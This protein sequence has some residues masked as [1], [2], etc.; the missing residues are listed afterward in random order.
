MPDRSSIPGF[1]IVAKWSKRPCPQ[2]N[3]HQLGLLTNANRFNSQQETELLNFVRDMPH[4]HG[5]MMCRTVG[6]PF[7]NKPPGSNA[8]AVAAIGIPNLQNWTEHRF[9]LGN[10]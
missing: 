1:I 7:V 6:V 10:Q 5:A 4:P 3:F 8:E 2:F 9:C